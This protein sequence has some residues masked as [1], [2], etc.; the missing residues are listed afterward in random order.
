MDTESL[1]KKL[2]KKLEKIS[3][4]LHKLRTDMVKEFAS[5]QKNVNSV[6]LQID[7]WAG[8][9]H[10]ASQDQISDLQEIALEAEYN[11]IISEI[12]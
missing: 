10:Q 7:N 2:M 4:E 3:G 11:E 1:E 9:L 12:E 5:K 6:T 8:E